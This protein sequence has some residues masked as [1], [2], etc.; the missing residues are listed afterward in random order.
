[1]KLINPGALIG[2]TGAV[3][4][5]LFLSATISLADDDY[6]RD[7]FCWQTHATS[8]VIVWAN[9][10]EPGEAVVVKV[11]DLLRRK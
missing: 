10:C 4:L 8:K 2:L 11:R 3:L 6:D 9:R 1:M 5:G 7:R